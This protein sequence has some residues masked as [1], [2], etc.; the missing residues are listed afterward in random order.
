R[1][2]LA[3]R[4]QWALRRIQAPFPLPTLI[5]QLLPD[6]NTIELLSVVALCVAMMYLGS[7]HRYGTATAM[8]VGLFTATVPRFSPV[9][10][11]LGVTLQDCVKYHRWFGTLM[12]FVMLLHGALTGLITKCTEQNPR[13]CFLGGR[14]NKSG[15]AIVLIYALLWIGTLEIVR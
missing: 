14:S 7:H 12:V 9:T 5:E 15:A 10:V 13:S 8:I 4:H 2:Y 1:I 11:L 3:S 6:I